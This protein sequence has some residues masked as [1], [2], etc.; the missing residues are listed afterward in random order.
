[1]AVPAPAAR[2]TGALGGV[3]RGAHAARYG[4]GIPT[5]DTARLASGRTRIRGRTGRVAARPCAH[6]LPP[7]AAHVRATDHLEDRSRAALGLPDTRRGA[8]AMAACA[9]A[10][11]GIALLDYLPDT[12]SPQARQARPR[13]SLTRALARAHG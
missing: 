7:L 5:G 13:G 9:V 11:P 3:S 6:A 10:D 4:R 12:Q 2:A 1:C 8:L